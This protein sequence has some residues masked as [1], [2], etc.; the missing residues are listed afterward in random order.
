MRIGIIGAGHIGGTLAGHFVGAGHGVAV[1]NSRGPAT[2]GNSSRSWGRWHERRRPKKPPP[3]ATWSWCRYPSAGT[4]NCRPTGF[5]G[6]IVIDTNNYD[7]RRDGHFEELDT[8]RSTSSELLQAHL[9]GSRVVKAFNA[10]LARSLRDLGRP[11]GG[12]RSR[13]HPALG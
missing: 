1:S 11:S 10:I 12:S 3:S 6:K 13:W 4:G 7:P 5:D 9:T 8:G 2:L